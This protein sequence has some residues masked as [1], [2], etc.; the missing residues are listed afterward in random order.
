MRG[1]PVARRAWRSSGALAGQAARRVAVRHDARAGGQG[2]AVQGARRMRRAA[3]ARVCSRGAQVREALGFDQCNVFFTGAAPIALEVLDY[4]GCVRRA[5]RSCAAV[6]HAAR[7]SSLGI[8][9]NEIYGMSESSGPQTCW[10]AVERA[11]CAWRLSCS[12]ARAA[13]G[14][15]ASRAPSACASP[16]WRR[17]LRCGRVRDA[18]L[19]AACAHGARRAHSTWRAATS[20]ARARSASAG[21]TSWSVPSRAGECAWPHTGAPAYT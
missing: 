21:A 4:F 1:R 12:A 18:P 10:Y 7:R 19:A 9:I 3:R 13:A 2:G 15:T 16:A 6:R 5:A 20:R 17:A 8:V 14:T 11:V